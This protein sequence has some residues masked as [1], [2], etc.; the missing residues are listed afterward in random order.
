MTNTQFDIF[1]KEISTES[2]SFLSQE[3]IDLS[4]RMYCTYLYIC[5]YQF[6]WGNT[7]FI[8]SGAISEYYHKIPYIL[9]S[10]IALIGNGIITNTLSPKDWAEFTREF[11]IKI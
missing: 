2:S 1:H 6:F 7:I 4:T 11:M 9:L 10:F 8:L 3:E 5:K